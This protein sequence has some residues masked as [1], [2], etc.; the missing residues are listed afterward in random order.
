LSSSSFFA[1]F[2]RLFCPKDRHFAA[3]VTYW[4]AI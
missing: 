2:N 1:M 4:Q 3:N